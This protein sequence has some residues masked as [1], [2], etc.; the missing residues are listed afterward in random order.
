MK[1]A[2]EY[3]DID[4]VVIT[5]DE[6]DPIAV[7]TSVERAVCVATANDDNFEDYMKVLGYDKRDLPKVEIIQV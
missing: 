6:G 4:S 7:A 3:K 5:T 1:P 2:T